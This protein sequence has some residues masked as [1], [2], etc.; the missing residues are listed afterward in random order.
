[1][2]PAEARAPARFGSFAADVAPSNPNDR[3]SVR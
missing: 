3:K 1:M 2:K